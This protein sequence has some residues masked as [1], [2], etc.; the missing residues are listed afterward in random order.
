MDNLN[1]LHR[2][3]IQSLPL[4]PW[5]QRLLRPAAMCLGPQATRTHGG[6]DSTF[7]PAACHGGHCYT[8]EGTGLEVG[9][10]RPGHLL[11]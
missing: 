10:Q 8:G 1:G 4:S 3:Q 11:R 2:E 9:Q 5:L 6:K 7:Q